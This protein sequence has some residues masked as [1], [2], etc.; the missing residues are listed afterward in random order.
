MESS[1]TAGCR[2]TKVRLSPAPRKA[3]QLLRD[4]QQSQEN[5]LPRP[6]LNDHCQ[7]CEFRR[8]C[9]EQVIREDNL[10]LLRGL[11]EKE[12]NGYARKDILTLP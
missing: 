9:H 10:S 8:R 3:E 5:E 7:V 12:V 1:G 4:L 2:A 11:G 6:F